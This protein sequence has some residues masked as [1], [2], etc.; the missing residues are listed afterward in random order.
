MNHPW[1]SRSQCR[2]I[3]PEEGEGLRL[4]GTLYPV[5]QRLSLRLRYFSPV[6]TLAG[7]DVIGGTKGMAF[8]Q[9]ADSALVTLRPREATPELDRAQLFE[10]HH[11]L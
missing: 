9:T 5:M 1:L 3:P 2:W 10:G 4:S 7:I 11:L 6:V 8:V